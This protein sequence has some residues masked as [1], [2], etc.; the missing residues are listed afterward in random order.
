MEQAMGQHQATALLRLRSVVSAAYEGS[1]HD[2]GFTRRASALLGFWSECPV[3]Y[4][5]SK[6]IPLV[7]GRALSIVGELTMCLLSV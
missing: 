3:V 4:T 5:A 7:R 6:Y 1:W 2:E